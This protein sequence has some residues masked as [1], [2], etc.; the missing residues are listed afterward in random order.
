MPS[1]RRPSA[2]RSFKSGL[3]YATY[4]DRTDTI[5]IV[6][7]VPDEVTDVGIAGTTVPATSDVWH[8]V[9]TA[10]QPLDFVVRSL[11]GTSASP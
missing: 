6:G 11:D 8:H 10:D 5:D 1:L 9:S 7:I 3:A 2:H 4:Q